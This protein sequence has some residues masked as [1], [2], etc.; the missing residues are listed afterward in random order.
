MSEPN[1]PLSVVVV[2]YGF[3]GRT[4]HAPLVQAA[5]DLSLDAIVTA[6][7]ARREQAAADY[8]GVAL[9]ESVEQ[10]WSAGHDLAAISTANVTHVPFASAAL[11]AG[12]HVVLDKP[13]AATAEQARELAARAAEADRLIVPF[14]N[15]RWDSDIRTAVKVAR[16]GTIGEVHRFESRITKMRIVPKD[17]WRVSAVTEDM[18]GQL[19]DLGIHASDQAVRLMGPV[20]SVAC[21]A[22]SVR[23][24]DPTDDDTTVVLT[25]TSGAISVLTVGQVQ[26]FAEPRM[27]LL[28][29]RGGLRI[30]P[31]DDQEPDMLNGI[32]PASPEWG[33]RRPGTE[34]V[35][36]VV[37]DD[38]S[39]REE[40]LALERGAWTEFYPAVARAVRGTGPVPVPIEDAIQDARILDAARL[41]SQT[42]SV[43]TLDPPAG[44]LD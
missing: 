6:N 27:L 24:G 37:A 8:P 40:R 15:R 35:L 44:H 11:G 20:A 29:T 19:Y 18:G 25:H 13:I 36:R 21:W 12:L 17:G 22:R 5:A 32:D 1:R 28:G 4:F 10:A 33:V 3:G 41:S 34:A 23:P 16:A 30:D 43:V 31:A 9:Y 26:A 38:N 7:P 42:G 2:G 39:V 14:Q